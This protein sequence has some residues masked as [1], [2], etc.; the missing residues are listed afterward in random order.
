VK[1]ISATGLVATFNEAGVLDLADV[2]L[3]RTL[4]TLSGD[5]NPEVA[6]AVALTMRAWRTGS[7]CLDI[8]RADALGF[9]DR[10]DVAPQ[11]TG[12][13]WPDPDAWLTTLQASPLIGRPHDRRPLCLDGDLLYLRRT[14]EAQA[15]VVDALAARWRAEPPHGEP[16]G[17]D[18]VDSVLTQWTTVLTGGPGTGKTTAIARL[19]EAV[20]DRFTRVAVAASTGKAAARL[21][22]A[23]QNLP[24]APRPSTLHALL[25]ARGPG[26]PMEHG[27]EN[28]LTADLVIV[29][30]LSMVSLPLMAAC[31]RALRPT[32]RLL[33]VGDPGQLASV[34]AGAVLADL[35]GAGVTAGAATDAPLV[36][37][38]THVYRHGGALA[39]LSVA[40]A[41]GQVDDALTVV[42]AGAPAVTLIDRDAAGLTWADLP[43]V[44]AQ[45]R[46]TAAAARSAAES[47][48]AVNGLRILDDHRLLCA[49]RAGPYGVATWARRVAE[50]TAPAGQTPTSWWAGRAVLAT[51]RTPDLG[52][53]SGDQGLAVATAAGLRLAFDDPSGVAPRL[54]PLT[55]VPGLATLD[56]MTVHKA[57]GSQYRAVTVILPPLDSPL[58]VRPLLYTAMTRASEKLTIVG[59]R[60]QLR[61][62]LETTPTRA[63]GLAAALRAACS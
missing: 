53:V 12:L 8:S 39:R 48:D 9:D 42:D 36:H 38:L 13:P 15:G 49:H 37:T 34:E 45:V 47:G 44:A 26:R 21:S 59:T 18:V 60:A 46:A 19:L 5:D 43:G 11:L 35:V 61:A 29:D 30:E 7:P 62:G 40:V 27:P 22:Q 54:L 17:D 28:P 16:V 6:L 50:L 51:A 20:S 14:W 57:Q 56:A 23:L 33:L 63:S 3:A 32:T 2:H 10:Q 55:A 1:A 25:G 52:V 24:G 58:L 41:A 4:A 31:L